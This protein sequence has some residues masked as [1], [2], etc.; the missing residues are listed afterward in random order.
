MFSFLCRK[1]M[2]L[3]KHVSIFRT[4]PPLSVHLIIS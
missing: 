1:H 2:F 4:Y 3:I